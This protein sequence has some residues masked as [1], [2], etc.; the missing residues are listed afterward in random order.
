MYTSDGSSVRGLAVCA[1]KAY[2]AG[3]SGWHSTLMRSLACG[4]PAL[5]NAS[6]TRLF[7]WLAHTS[8]MHCH[9]SGHSSSSHTAPMPWKH[10]SSSRFTS[11]SG[12]S[13]LMASRTGAS[14]VA[15]PSAT[16][17][18]TASIRLAALL[19]GCLPRTSSKVPYGMAAEVGRLTHGGSL[20][21]SASTLSA[22]APTTSGVNADDGSAH[23]P[24][25]A[26]S[27]TSTPGTAAA[28]V[29][30]SAAATAPGA[31]AT[32]APASDFACASASG[33]SPGSGASAGCSSAAALAA[34]GSTPIST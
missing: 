31:A 3:S 1:T 17:S 21:R 26:F 28:D 20:P 29:G 33:A 16:A 32:S 12:R 30:A 10:A 13:C 2:L 27:A 34:G 18:T 6:T 14:A 8:V 25:Q 11:W 7:H 24:V 4:T 19:C 5:A 9:M 22:L 15:S 23:F